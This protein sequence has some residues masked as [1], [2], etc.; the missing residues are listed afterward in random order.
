VNRYP[1]PLSRETL[2]LLVSFAKFS[3]T[4]GSVDASLA[5]LI[6]RAVWAKTTTAAIW[7]IVLCG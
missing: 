1:T 3:P 4:G 7:L 6:R 2:H 5:G